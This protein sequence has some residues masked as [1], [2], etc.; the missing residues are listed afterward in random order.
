VDPSSGLRLE[1]F[2]IS[3]RSATGR[4][5]QVA[6]TRGALE[7]P[8]S[9]IDAVDGRR[10]APSQLREVYRRGLHNPRFPFELSP[11]EIGTFLSHR[12][13]WSRI[14]DSGLDAGLVLED[15]IELV[16]P[17]FGRALD[18]AVAALGTY[19]LV[20]LSCRSPCSSGD[21]AAR[22]RVPLLPPLGNTSQLVRHDAA[23]RLLELSEQIDR[24][25][26]TFEQ[27]TWLHGLRVAIVEPSGVRE[28]SA[29]LGGTTIHRADRGTLA[30]IMR[31]PVRACYRARARV[32]AIMHRAARI[33][34]G[35]GA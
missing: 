32:R 23:R 10:M 3:L 16:E 25:V 13:A 1:A 12:L 14:V 19:Q 26:D 4:H 20:R 2:V 5:A 24:P 15:D 8:S 11:A 6:R 31:N 22:V 30:R 34:A 17:S 35:G 27:M 33:P 9:V 21:G 7:I 18:A 29:G 28:V